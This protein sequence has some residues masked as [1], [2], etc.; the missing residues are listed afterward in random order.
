MAI[1][2]ISGNI[3]QDNLQRGANLSIQGNLFYADVVNTRLGV[4]TSSTTATLTVAGNAA[5]STTLSVNGNATVGNLQTA[6]ILTATGNVTG[7]NIVTGGIVSAT[8]NVTG[9]YIFGNGSQLTGIDATS[10]Q[11]GNSNVRV[12]ANGNVSASIAGTSNVVVIAS[13]GEYVTGVVSAS[14]NVTGNGVTLSAN[15][16]SAASGILNLGSNANIKITGGSPNYILTTD[17]TGNVAWTSA[18]GAGVIGNTI[19]MGTN[20]LGNLVSNAVTL[21][22]STTVTDGITQL[23]TVL[24]KLV[25]ASPP[26]F[27]NSTTLLIT[28][29]TSSGRMCNFVQTDNTP[30]ANKAVA[31]GTVVSVVRSSSYAT[32]TISNTGPGDS[33]TLTVYLNGAGAGNAT[34]NTGASPTANGT[35]SNLVVTN[36]YDYHTANSSIAAG[37][38]YVFTSQASG[39]VTQG[40]NEVYLS[41]SVTANTNS[42]NWYYDASAPGTP[43]FSNVSVT[44]SASPSLTYSSTIPHY[45]SGTQ[46]GLG[47]SVN[48]LSGDLY[49]NNGNL[50]TNSTAAGGAFQ[51]PASVTY[52]A[53]NVTVPLT[54]NLYVSSGTATGNTTANIV[55]SG[56]GSSATGP[57]ITVTNSYNSASQAFT[58]ALAATVLYKNGNITAIDEGNVIVTSV[59]TG[60]G[61]AYRI[62][63]PGAGNTP[64]YTGSESAFNSQSSTLQT[65]DATVVGLGSA[66][67]L[68]HDQTNYSTGYLPAGPNLSSGRT[69]T[70]YFTFKFVRTNV[71]KFDITYSGNVAGMWVALPGSVIDASSSANGWINMA[72]A[73]GGAGYPGVNAPGNGSDGCSLGGVVPVNVNQASAINRTC[74]FGTVS[75]SSTATNE[76][77]VRV[78]LTSGQTVSALSINAASN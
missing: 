44:A 9:S 29:A 18:A 78:A 66:G 33:G 72:T 59:G 41:D 70:Q 39:V 40:W 13:T 26:N 6:G 5:I 50:L 4:N 3:L 77:Y 14:G 58:T 71:S 20:T 49:P 60:S 19:A 69:G 56:F 25:P 65:Y 28:T 46:F 10:I 1:N 64:I 53:A 2:K 16:I 51:A 43:A 73:Y 63:N 61:N 57:S 47:F 35:Y 37:F 24:G 34:F 32:N 31:A 22:T 36:N 48:K 75:S 21:T 67:V 74:T 38:W 76:I 52:A 27:P 12:Y 30:G 54:R 17:G 23:N 7:G 45:N 8:G 15:A 42:P 62:V 55:A 11:N 68:K